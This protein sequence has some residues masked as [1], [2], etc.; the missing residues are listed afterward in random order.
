MLFFSFQVYY[1]EQELYDQRKL[2]K[3]ADL[4]AWDMTVGEWAGG[5]ALG[6]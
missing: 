2:E 4:L 3:I 5:F 1:S 6:L